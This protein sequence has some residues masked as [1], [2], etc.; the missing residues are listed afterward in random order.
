MEIILI[1][2]NIRS[3]QNVGAIFRTADAV[4][5]ERIYLLGYTPTPLDRFGRVRAD[6]HKSALGAEESV[7][8]SQIDDLEDLVK[9]LKADKFDIVALEQDPKAEDYR[10]YKPKSA[11]VALVVGNE[12]EGISKSVLDICDSIIEL[13]MRGKKESLNVSVAV[14]IALYKLLE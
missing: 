10:N 11:K 4:G 7:P 14:G 5:V 8:Y 9:K 12:T 3:V 1:L 2:D 6:M 13:P